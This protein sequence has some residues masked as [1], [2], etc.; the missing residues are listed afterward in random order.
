[1][2]WAPSARNGN[3]AYFDYKNDALVMPHPTSY[4]V[5]EGLLTQ[6]IVTN[7]Q[8]IGAKIETSSQANCPHRVRMTT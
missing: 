3:I 5:S 8:N 1:M 4:Y 7:L 2:D 6:A